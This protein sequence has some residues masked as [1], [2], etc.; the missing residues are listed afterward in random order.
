MTTKKRLLKVFLCHARADT[1]SVRVYYVR[2]K[3]DG[4]DVWLDEARLVLGQDREYEIRKAVRESDIVIVFHSK[5][6]NQKGFHQKEVKIALEEAESLPKGAIFIIPA[7]LEECDVLDDLQHLLCVDLFE[8]EDKDGNKDDAYESLLSTLRFRANEVD[9]ILRVRRNRLSKVFP[10]QLRNERFVPEHLLR[11]WLI[12]H[13]I[14]VNPFEHADL[15]GYPFYPVGAVW[16]DQ[17]EFLLDPVPI[18][19]HCPSAEDAQ[20]LAYLLRKECLPLETDNSV[21]GVNRHIF[22]IW[23]WHQ[24]T[25]PMQSPL[26]T[27][28]HSA[29]R[30]WLDIL[31]ARPHALL[32]LPLAEQNTLLELLYWSLGSKQALVHLIELNGQPENENTLT[33]LRKITEVESEFSSTYVPHDAVLLSRLKI[34][35][36]G[37]DQTYLILPGD[38]LLPVTPAWWFKRFGSLVSALPLDG[39]YIKMFASSSLSTPLSTSLSLHEM[40][41]SWPK[42]WLNRSLNGQFDAAMHPEEKSMGKLI[43]FHELFGPGV[44]EEE[45][46]EK[47]IS[48]SHHSLVRMLAIGNRLLQNHCWKKISETYLSLE[49]LEDILKTV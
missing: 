5:Q 21:L 47:L 16:P 45:T 38:D 32:N 6:F 44:T 23:V 17:W 18:F 22:P 43:R 33:L 13:G 36:F 7:R 31:P 40:E 48:A 24:Q 12:R 8:K 35:P 49:E 34:R 20:A 9:A 37:M 26:L 2:L 4:L 11:S 30:T 42:G 10:P 29:A 14:V 1:E 19:A 25:T 39:I 41:L 15:K 46:T 27:L 28:A 3:H